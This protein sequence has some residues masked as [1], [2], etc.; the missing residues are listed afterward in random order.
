V[1][2]G[3][4]ANNGFH[5]PQSESGKIAYGKDFYQGNGNMFFFDAPNASSSFFAELS[6]FGKMGES[7]YLIQSFTWGYSVNNGKTIGDPLTIEYFPSSTQELWIDY[8][9]FHNN[10]IF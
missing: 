6:L 8:A 9:L 3:S 4:M 10:P 1:E 2:N 5:Y 7:W